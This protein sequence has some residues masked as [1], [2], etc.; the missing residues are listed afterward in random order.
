M[1]DGTRWAAAKPDKW[2]GHLCS[3]IEDVY[4]LDTTFDQ[5]NMGHPHLKAKPLVIDPRET[6]WFDPD[7]ARGCPWTGCLKMFDTTVRYSQFPR[8]AGWKNT[9]GF[10]PRQRRDVVWKADRPNSTNF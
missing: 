1:G 10:R 2:K 9:P 3:L 4:L 6:K 8:Q 7:P 5:C